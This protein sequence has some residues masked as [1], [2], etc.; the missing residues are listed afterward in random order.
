MT[1][2]TEL[3]FD[4]DSVTPRML[5]DFHEKTGTDLM[6]LFSGESF[7]TAD[8]DALQLAGLV[9]LALRMN[10]QPQATWDDA[11]DTPITSLGFG[12][13]PAEAVPPDPTPASSAAS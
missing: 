5:V 12:D 9:W 7:N 3:Q 10:G 13:A 6:K 4:I 11:L 8:L 2:P 1:V